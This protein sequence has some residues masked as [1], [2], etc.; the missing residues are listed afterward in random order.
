MQ[1]KVKTIGVNKMVG[2]NECLK[3]TPY[4]T[5]CII[6]SKSAIIYVFSKQDFLKAIGISEDAVKTCSASSNKIANEIQ[7]LY[8]DKLKQI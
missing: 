6:E 2:E 8:M 3:N 1:I 4:Q 7:E 5:S